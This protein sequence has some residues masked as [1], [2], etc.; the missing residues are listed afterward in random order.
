MLRKPP[1]LVYEISELTQGKQPSTKYSILKGS[2]H[3]KVKEFVED[4]N[5]GISEDHWIFRD[6]KG[7]EFEK[8]HPFMSLAEAREFSENADLELKELVKIK[9]RSGEIENLLE[10]PSSLVHYMSRLKPRLCRIY[11]L[12]INNVKAIQIRNK[13]E[14]WLRQEENRIM[15]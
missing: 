8:V 9:K 15:R 5:I 12:G 1:K 11:V 6:I 3:D 7:P 14:D 13:I 2:W 4:S 10:D